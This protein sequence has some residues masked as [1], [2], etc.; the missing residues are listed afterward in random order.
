MAP[1]SA[2]WRVGWAGTRVG[3]LR[4]RRTCTVPWPRPPADSCSG[5][6]LGR[7]ATACRLRSR[8]LGC[9][10]RLGVRSS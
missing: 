5:P 2:G 9:R 7:T 10:V 1:I 4:T 8:C 3:Y 6:R